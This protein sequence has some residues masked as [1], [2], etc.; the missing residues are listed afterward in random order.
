MSQVE[1]LLIEYSD[2]KIN[3]PQWEILDRGVTALW[4]PSGAGKTTVFRALLG[5]EP[6]QK[7]KWTFSEDGKEIDLATL[8]TPKR[9]LGVVFQTLD[10][11]PHMSARE[12]MRFAAEA[13]GLNTSD[14]RERETE[15]IEVMRMQNFIDRS[16]S[17]L[18][19]GEKQRVALARALIARPRVLFLDEPFSALDADL[20]SE[21]R[22]LVKS[23]ITKWQIPTVL[24]THDKDDLSALA[25]KVSKISNGSIV[26]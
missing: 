26:D 23:A 22:S 6:V 24:I 18:S 12:N 10:L 1:N 13:R 2:F 8:P 16:A 9:N 4:G 21:A 19:G 5:L 17:L 11:F 3:I 25:D 7:L 14:S 20:R 15:L